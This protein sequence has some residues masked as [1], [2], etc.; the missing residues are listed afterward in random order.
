MARVRMVV[1][2]LWTIGLAT[3]GIV[4]LVAVIIDDIIRK[5]RMR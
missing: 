3:V 4:I 1:R 2:W 5:A